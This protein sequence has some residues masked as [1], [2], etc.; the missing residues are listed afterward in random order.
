MELH[1]WLID[2]SHNY[3]S[4]LSVGRHVIVAAATAKENHSYAW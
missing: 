3:L 1:R 4:S 2:G